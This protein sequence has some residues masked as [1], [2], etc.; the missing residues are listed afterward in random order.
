MTHI[1][2]LR[3]LEGKMVEIR[4]WMMTTLAVDNLEDFN[5][6]GIWMV[7]GWTFQVDDIDSIEFFARMAV[8][9]LTNTDKN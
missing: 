7:G 5:G 8:I 4:N 6:D 3:M 9:N 1:Q 2:L